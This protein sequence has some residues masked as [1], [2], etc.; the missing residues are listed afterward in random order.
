MRFDNIE[1][2]IE[3]LAPREIQIIK[4]IATGMSATHIQL[5]LNITK[6]TFYSH[7]YRLYYKIG[8]TTRE[9]VVIFAYE[10]GLIK[11]GVNTDVMQVTLDDNSNPTHS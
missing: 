11:V 7:L 5:D 9:E 3:R 10:S 2:V 8:I 1:L 6:N 4:M